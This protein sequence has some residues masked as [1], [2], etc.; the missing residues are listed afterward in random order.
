MAG[1]AYPTAH[2]GD[3]VDTY[4]GIKVADPYRWMEKIDAPDTRA[5]VTAEDALTASYIS[6]IP[7]RDVFA[8]RLTALFD[9]ETYSEPFHEGDHYFYLHNQGL[10][11]QSVLYTADSLDGT[12]RVLLDP[13]ALST[14]GSVVLA[15]LAMNRD[16]S[17]LAYSLSQGGSDW[18]EW[19]LRDVASGK[20]LADVLK[21][22][23]YYAVA[24][25]PDG[26]G[27]YYSHFPAPPAGHE[28]DETDHDNKVYY[29]VVGTAQDADVLVYETPAQPDRQFQPYVTRDGHT[30]VLAMGLGEVGDRDLEEVAVGDLTKGPTPPITPIIQ[31]F[32]ARYDYAGAEAPYLYFTTDLDAPDGRVIA[33]DP[34]QPARSAWKEIIPQ[35]TD[36]IEGVSLV[37][38]QLVVH[39]LQDARSAVALYG[40]DGKKVR[41]IDLPGLGVAFGF[42]GEPDDTETFYTFM[43][44]TTPPTVYRY[45]LV[46]GKTTLYRQPKVA[47]DP[48]DYETD[49]VFYPGKDGTKIPMFVAHRKD[50]GLSAETPLLLTGYGG[51]DISMIP[52]FDPSAIA[53]MEQGGIYALADIRGGGEYGE[54]WH[55]AAMTVHKQTT[56]DDFIAAA[57]WLIENHYTSTPKLAIEGG[58]NGGLLMGACLTQRPDLYGAVLAD[59]GVLDMLRFDKFGQGQGWEGDYGSPSD[60]DDFKALYAY[61]PLHNVHVGTH[62]PA[63]LITTGDHDTRVFPAHSYKFAATLQAAQ[64]GPAPILIRVE[65]ES[66][67][68]GGG[69]T[70]Q[71]IDQTADSYAFAAK[72][73]G[74]NVQ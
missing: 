53:W 24:F 10:Q 14:D 12:P 18:E 52:Y 66:G 7:A 25:T 36:A 57:E 34:S 46:A 62:Y 68:G 59:V 4:F 3:V 44:P 33:I 23:K 55:Q 48:A 65:V 15:N 16:G 49:Q 47:F 51:F 27:L 11:P 35:G 28:L 17:I 67:H 58:S 43:S 50:V 41:D 5:W 37:H 61:S 40:L 9:H 13:N 31:G 54:A 72:A 21:W 64:G 63:T 6:A 45:D 42:G 2:K 19:H 56:F 38:H 22:S 26:K 20:D 8:N 74:M 29:H 32:D 71:Q 69:T 30:L 73:L 39:R 60:P 1:L 70:Q